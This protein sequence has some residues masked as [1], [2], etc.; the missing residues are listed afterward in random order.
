MKRKWFALLGLVL[1]L[2]VAVVPSINA[3][4][5]Y[6]LEK[7]SEKI[8]VYYGDCIIDVGKNQF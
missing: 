6:Q 5:G 2:G 4:E 1:F 8:T 7:T 3:D